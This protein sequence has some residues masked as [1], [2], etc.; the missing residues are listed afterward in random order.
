MKFIY[1]QVSIFV[2]FLVAFSACENKKA[3]APNNIVY[4]S[5]TV[6]KIYHLE[7][8]ST[9]PSCSVKIRYIF[10]SQYSDTTI[11]TRIQ[12]EFNYALLEE[13][14]YEDLSPANAVD[15]FI[16]DYIANY[17]E[18]AKVQFPDWATSEETDDYF[19]FYKTLNSE[20]LFDQDG[21]ISYQTSSM[22]FKGGANSSTFYKN[23]IIDLKTG[24]TVAEKDIFI[25]EYKKLLN[26]MLTDKIV[27]QNNVKKAEDL[28]EFGYW[29][30]EDIASNNNFAIDSK[31]IT[32]LFN[33]GEYSAPSLGAIK[34]AF[35]FSELSPILKEDS[36]ISS[37]SGK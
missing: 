10:P 11:L 12:R 37:L 15:K 27:A 4:D 25:P 14:S 35:T 6:S 28:L 22:D 16:T 33:Q 13:E 20:V 23:V 5:I 17:K 21:I 9:K 29:G 31:G 2:L 8:D 34:V 7:N 3:D 24:N 26:T 1:T 30:I 18:A 32:Y 19:S 36:P